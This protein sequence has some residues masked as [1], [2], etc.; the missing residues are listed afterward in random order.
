M[1][2]TG[3]NLPLKKL[4][5][6]IDTA[7]KER[8]V[9]EIVESDEFKLL[10]QQAS[11]FRNQSETAIESGLEPEL[12]TNVSG[13]DRLE[14]ALKVESESQNSPAVNPQF[15]EHCQQELARCIGPLAH[16]M[17]EDILAESPDLTPQQLVE[18]LAAE[19]SESG[20]SQN[21][22]DSI[23]IP[24]A[25]NSET[26]ISESLTDSYKTGDLRDRLNPQFLEHCRQELMCCM[27]PMASFVLEDILAQSP[28]LALEQLIEV[29]VAEI[30][31][32]QRAQEF[33]DRL[34]IN[35]LTD[36]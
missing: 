2:A 16:C 30:P 25:S 29:L 13:S 14:V 17:I 33:K 10:E 1:D 36:V 32:Y 22:L 5:F 23:Q 3:A 19:I 27:G 35:L 20:R 6:K 12:K 8:E 4:E 31:D 26:E 24:A 28:H 18:A 34:Q 15:L 7:Q 21:F 9:A 11:K